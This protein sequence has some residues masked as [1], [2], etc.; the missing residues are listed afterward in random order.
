ML[1][2]H[3]NVLEVEIFVYC[4][5]NRRPEVGDS[6]RKETFLAHATGD[7][8]SRVKRLCLFGIW[9]SCVLHA[10]EVRAAWRDPESWYSVFYL[11]HSNLSLSP[12]ISSWVI[13]FLNSIFISTWVLFC[14]LAEFRFQ[15]LIV[16]VIVQ[17]YVC[18]SWAPLGC[19]LMFCLSLLSSSFASVFFV[20]F[21]YR[22]SL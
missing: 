3:K 9:V 11:N 6:L 5:C 17:I 18:V 21:V 14:L 1:C 2:S 10:T 4:C 13:T 15:I 16:L 22:V 19:L 7:R 12:E 20:C 8:K